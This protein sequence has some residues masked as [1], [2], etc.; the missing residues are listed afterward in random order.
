MDIVND[1][2][3]HFK[4]SSPS[5]VIQERKEKFVNKFTCH[6]LLCH[7]GIDNVMRMSDACDMSSSTSKHHVTEFR[8]ITR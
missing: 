7:F 1:C 8:P 5:E 3:L 6:N 2:L 4:I